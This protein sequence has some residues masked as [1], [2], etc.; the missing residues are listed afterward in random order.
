[1]SWSDV[2]RAAA[3]GFLVVVGL[4]L[5][6]A[7]VR[8]ARALDRLSE[9]V[10]RTVDEALPVLGKAGEAL[11]QV[12]GQLAHAE[13]VTGAAADALD[14]VERSTRAVVD[15]VGRPITAVA[16]AVSSVDRAVR[17]AARRPRD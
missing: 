2:L 5:A 4:T 8:A 3:S 6:Y 7:L 1:M 17:R 11:D 16:G 9:A 15:G 14:A 12:S 13:R 10:D